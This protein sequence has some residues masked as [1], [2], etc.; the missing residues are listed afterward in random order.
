MPLECEAT[1]HMSV[2]LVE[3]DLGLVQALGRA[4]AARGFS[5]VSCGDGLEALALCQRQRFDAIVLDLSLPDIDGL[6]VMARLRGRDDVTPVLIL[7]A[8]GAV[9]ERVMGLN[10][11]ADDYL[12]KP[13]DL[14][15]LEAR[16]RAL[17][18]RH[19]GEGDL[20]C[21]RLRLE[22]SGPACW[23][24]E[25]PLDLPAREAALLRALMLRSGQTVAREHLHHAVFPVNEPGGPGGTSPQGDALDVVVHRLRKRLAGAALEIVTLR[26]IGY[27]L[28]E[29]T[30]QTT[31]MVKRARA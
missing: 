3:D 11:G 21:G 7:T 30:A 29:D 19:Q 28:C 4:L 8:R 26:G 22:R 5:L 2:L 31:G 25:R 10:A 1:L 14:D 20:R 23:I 18:R 16:L 13:F 6:E 27:M 9:G 24:D 12:V 15:E 17:I